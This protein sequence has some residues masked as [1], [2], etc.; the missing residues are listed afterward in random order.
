MDEDKFKKLIE[1]KN[2]IIR[3]SDLTGIGLNQR[4][5]NNLENKGVIEKVGRGIYNHKNYFVDMLAVY[6]MNNS[7]LIYSLET[8]AY[9]HSLTDRFPRFYSVTTETGYHLRKDSELKVTYIKPSLLLLGVVDIKD[10]LGNLIKVYDKER[11]VCDFIRYKDRIEQQVYVEV[12]QNY[13]KSKVDLNKL[14]RYAKQLNITAKVFE[15]VVL[16]TNP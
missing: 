2:G 10:E 14:A 8:A 13:F 16:M 3:Y 6:Q 9:L 15:I 1:E 11:T 7:K 4:Q 12:I 5:I